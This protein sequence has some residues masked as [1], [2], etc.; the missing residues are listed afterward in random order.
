M[1]IAYDTDARN[2]KPLQGAIVRRYTA[3]ATIEAGQLLYV[4]SSGNV[5]LAAGG[6]VAT[7]KPFIGVAL[8]DAVAADVID[9]VVFGPVQCV[10]G[11]TP[12][13]TAYIGDTA[14][15]PV[16]T[17]GTKQFVIGLVESATVLFIRPT[18]LAAAAS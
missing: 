16:E 18:S 10:T 15:S 6:A 4:N 5:D 9:V 2:I 14:G 11:G 13:S 17:A 12:G 7:T 3:A 8:Q 1:A